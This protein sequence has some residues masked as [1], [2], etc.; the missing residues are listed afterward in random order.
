MSPLG[1][2]SSSKE[3]SY[4]M[5]YLLAPRVLHF[6][7]S[8]MFWESSELIASET[9]Q[10]GLP[11]RIRDPWIPRELAW[12]AFRSLPDHSENVLTDS[13]A[14]AMSEIIWDI[15]PLI[16]GH[17]SLCGLT[18]ANEK[19]F[20]LSRMTK[21]IQQVFKID[22]CAGFWKQDLEDQLFWTCLGFSGPRYPPATYRAPTWSWASVD[23]PL[24]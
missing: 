3:T 12:K 17:F 22:Y 14:V 15:W 13:N 20:A 7:E 4:L 9:Y 11:P 23:G 18:S 2:F 19:L 21:L 8:E 5:T 24:D 16:V 10:S 1:M 6:C